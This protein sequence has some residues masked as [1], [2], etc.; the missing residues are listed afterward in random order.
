M[1]QLVDVVSRDL[2]ELIVEDLTKLEEDLED[3]LALVPGDAYSRQQVRT[4]LTRYITRTEAFLSRVRVRKRNP[5][6]HPRLSLVLIHCE[7]EIFDLDS[8]ETQVYRL[9]HPLD[10]SLSW[11]SLSYISPLGLAL[12]AKGSGETVTIEIPGGSPKFSI[13]QI[14]LC[15]NSHKSNETKQL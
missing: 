13:R 14:Y 6:Q 3:I 7:I 8:R 10:N 11:D 9:S 5:P 12:L 15:R 1:N 4:A 2:F